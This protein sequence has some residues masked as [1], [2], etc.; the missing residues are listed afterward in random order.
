[1][2]PRLLIAIA[3]AAG[4]VT[5]AILL[6]PEG[7]ITGPPAHPWASF[8]VGTWVE[9]RE[10]VKMGEKNTGS[11]ER[12]E[13]IEIKPEAVRLKVSTRY[14]FGESKETETRDQ[15]VGTL[16]EDLSLKDFVPGKSVE[17][18]VGDQTFACRIYTRLK[19]T[20]TT[21]RWIA[22]RIPAWPLRDLVVTDN[23]P[24]QETVDTALLDLNAIVKVKDRE[25]PCQMFLEVHASNGVLTQKTY[26]WKSQKV[27][28][29][30]VRRLDGLS[31]G[32]ETEMVVTGLNP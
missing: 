1:M 7:P 24:Q 22:D 2:K 30:L 17:R 3:L 19:G 4:I 26:L 18:E 32:V 10:A 5:A 14:E 12:Y 9:R 6:R 15:F 31:E 13:V 11:V 25:I 20:T 16:D 21:T 23:G 29:H 28:G 8:P 27:P